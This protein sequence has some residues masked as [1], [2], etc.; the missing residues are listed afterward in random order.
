MMVESLCCW[1]ASHMSS[2]ESCPSGHMT[3]P[4]S[5]SSTCSWVGRMTRIKSRNFTYSGLMT[6]NGWYRVWMTA[7]EDENVWSLIIDVV[8]VMGTVNG[9]T[10][11]HLWKQVKQAH[12]DIFEASPPGFNG[13]TPNLVC[14]HFAPKVSWSTKSRDRGWKPGGFSPWGRTGIS[15]SEMPFSERHSSRDFCH[16]TPNFV[17]L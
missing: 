8:E 1:Y 12:K 5:I 17:N 4:L 6:R 14:D 9:L 10:H 15:H 2:L 7:L 16:T 3:M 11:K 13:F